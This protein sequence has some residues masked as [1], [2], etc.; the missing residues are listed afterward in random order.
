MNKMWCLILFDCEKEILGEI[1][2]FQN[3]GKDVY[4]KKTIKLL[5]YT[6]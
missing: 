6:Y 5:Q 4:P 2:E 3:H 1:Y